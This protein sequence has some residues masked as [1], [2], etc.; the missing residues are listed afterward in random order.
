MIKG[1]PRQKEVLKA[2]ALRFIRRH[3]SEHLT[4]DYLVS[5]TAVVLRQ[6]FIL[7]DDDSTAIAELALQEFLANRNPK[8]VDSSR[9]TSTH[10]VITD[11]ST[12]AAWAIPADVVF[13]YVIRTPDSTRFRIANT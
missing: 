1:C 2:W 10:T 13:E 9:S 8:A 11:P 5:R 7:S 3:H 6:G 4:Y 12:G